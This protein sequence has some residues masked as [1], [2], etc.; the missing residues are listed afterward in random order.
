MLRSLR[1]LGAAFLLLATVIGLAGAGGGRGSATAA[2]P[3]PSPSATA[4]PA[5]TP[6]P[7]PG[8]AQVGPL[9]RLP[10]H[11]LQALGRAQALARLPQV[12]DQPITVTV[13]LNRTDESGF[14][15][16]LEAVQD[17]RSPSYRRFLS[18]SQLADRFGPTAQASAAVRSY[19]EA[20]GF[21][22]VQD[23]A[24]RL[25]LTFQG[26]RAQAEQAF[27][28]QINDFQLSSRSFFANT[29]DPAVPANLSTIVRTVAGLNNL[30]RPH[31]AAPAQALAPALAG[32][33]PT[34]MDIAQF[35]NFP[36]IG[37]A[38]GAGQRVGLVEFST[39]NRSDVSAWLNLVGL[40]SS[41]LNNVGDKT[42]NG[43]TSDTSGQIEDVLDIDVILGMAPGAAVIDYQAPNNATSWSQMFNTMLNDGDTVISNS[44]TNCEA[45]DTLANVQG[46]DSIFAS[47][48]AGGVAIFSASADNLSTCFGGSTGT[49]AYPNTISV[50]SDIPHGIAIGGTSFSLG[51]GASYGSEQFWNAGGSPP[52][53]SGFGVSQFFPLPSFQSGLTTAT[54]RSIPDV[55]AAASPGIL[56]CQAGC[57]WQVRGT[58]LATPIWAAGAARLNQQLGGGLGGPQVLYNAGGSAYHSAS[59]MGSDFAHLGLG[60]PNMGG[61]YQAVAP[62]RTPGAPGLQSPREGATN[63]TLNPEITW[64]APTAAVP[65]TTIYTAYVWDPGARVMRFQQATT[66]TSVVVSPSLANGTFYYYT[67]QACNG[68]SC[69]ALARWEGFTTIGTPGMPGLTAPV[70]GSSGVSVNPTFQWTAPANSLDG[71]TLYTL[72]VWDPGAGRMALQLSTYALSQQLAPNAGLQYGT[73]YYFTVQACNGGACGPAARWEGF[74][75]I[76]TPGAPRLSSPAEGSSGNSLTPTLQW[77]APA[78]SAAGTTQYTAFIWDPSGGVMAFQAATTALA[79]AV[80]Q[81]SALQP[82]HFYYYTAQACN[83]PLCGPIARWEGFT[84]IGAPGT[85]TLLNPLEGSTGNGVT[86]TIRWSAPAGSLSGTTQYTV[87]VWDPAAGVMKFQQT[88]TA[89]QDTVTSVGGLQAGHFYYYTVQACNG[90]ACGPLARWEGFTS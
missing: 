35:Y 90:S 47:A 79:I 21:A 60:S 4:T 25:T 11:T 38:N 80:P 62:T 53:G 86:P 31:R 84:T 33:L 52:L 66:S 19:M 83:G 74:T 56:V 70:E 13:V 23:S 61:V 82:G 30:A 10:G 50:P 77:N 72:S 85:P 37:S 55:A 20:Q 3:S 22:L 5:P 36:G 75:T 32:G 49:T 89:L 17:P 71:T 63:V 27:A 15:S 54:M 24:N 87:Y 6:S 57:Q 59:S 2:T 76:G 12:A 18:Q 46:I 64:S 42:V 40:P 58:S 69:G 48:A 1:S 9:V 26:T 14:E 16:F 7:A 45:D 41:L 88:T 44:W 51:P 68:S 28:V 65:G 29:S 43:G 39:Y 73:F 34:P 67:V 8:P 78:G 81:G